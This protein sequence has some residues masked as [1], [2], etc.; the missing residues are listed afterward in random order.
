MLLKKYWLLSYVL[1]WS[2]TN[3]VLLFWGID[4]TIASFNALSLSGHGDDP[5]P[6]ATIRR[7]DGPGLHHVP[8]R[9]H[10]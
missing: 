1:L 8:G 3:P 6:Q 7:P 4:V 2:L 9:V 10:N 5:D